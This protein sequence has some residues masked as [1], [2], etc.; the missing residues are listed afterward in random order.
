MKKIINIVLVTCLLCLNF[1][2][3]LFADENGFDGVYNDPYDG[4]QTVKTYKSMDLDLEKIDLKGEGNLNYKEFIENYDFTDVSDYYKKAATELAALGISYGI[5]NK[6]FGGEQKIKNIEA[7]AMLLRMFNAEEP[8]RKKVIDENKEASI[9]KLN[10]YF[11]DA[12]VEEAQNRGILSKEESLP[13]FHEAK[14]EDIADW[15][16]K[17]SN[18]SNPNPR[19]LIEKASDVGLIKSSNYTSVETLVDLGIMSISFGNEFGTKKPVKRRDFAKMLETTISRFENVLN[20]KKGH[21]MIIGFRDVKDEK[22]SYK[23]I[24]LRTEDNTIESLRYGKQNDG[25]SLGFPTLNSKLLYPEQLQ[26]NNELEYLIKD[27]KIILA[28]ILHSNEVKLGIVDK[29]AKDKDVEIIQGIVKSNKKEK[30]NTDRKKV[31]INRLRVELDDDRVV[32]FVDEKDLITGIN[33]ELLVKNGSGFIPAESISV[34]SAI[35]A[36]IKDDKVLFIQTGRK[37][38]EVVKGELRAID[39]VSEPKTITVF[40]ENSNLVTLPVSEDT[41][42]TVN[43]YKVGLNSLKVGS[44]V[45]VISVR[46]VAEFVKL[47][48]YQPPEGYIK[49]QGKIKFAVVNS[50]D[51]N[52]LKLNGD[53]DYCEITPLTLIKKGKENIKISNILVGDKVKLYYDDIYTDSPSKIVVEETGALIKKIL[54]AEISDYS[55]ATQEI[56]IKNPFT[57]ENS[58]WEIENESYTSSYKLSYDSEIFVNGFKIKKENLKPDYIGKTAYMVIR[59]GLNSKE[60][61]K[62]VFSDKYEKNI[63]DGIL[64]FDNT[65]NRL[66]L[67]GGKTIIFNDETIFIEKDR[68]VSKDSLRKGLNLQ[69]ITNGSDNFDTAKLVKMLGDDT[70]NFNK[71]FIAYI[72][73][74]N[75]FSVDIKNYAEMEKTKFSRVLTEKKNL[76]ISDDTDIFDASLGNYVSRE[77]FFNGDYYKK[78]YKKSDNK[79]LKFKR[80]YGLFITDGEDNLIAAKI[81]HKGLLENDIID[82]KLKNEFQVAEHLDE[83]INGLN[84]TKGKITEFQ[85]KWHRVKLENSFNHFS[86]HNEWKPNDKPTDVSLLNALIMKKNKIINYEDLKI[87]DKLFIVRDDEDGL[88]VF[89]E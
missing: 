45:S 23:D 57:Y 49:K 24:L 85:P 55:T 63:N 62:L 80:Y 59:D 5:G 2:V 52:S 13:Y 34:D 32:D 1:E 48:S 65:L 33:N 67:S 46:G 75:P 70:K 76:K 83:I 68:L 84:F 89:V 14:R 54:K 60:I 30:I 78:E 3:F 56:K 77:S 7:I 50:V 36:Y 35:T 66:T 88:L 43:Y 42:Y 87:N 71:V 19:R 15:F 79:G 81:R 27:G 69:I 72:D 6:K 86:Y 74:V 64:N 51:K 37:A 21:G 61:S 16:V 8:I 26:K 17:A 28:R 9:D 11:Y 18:L 25:R 53:I 12:Y 41:N 44:F 4:I 40:D 47:A 22:G 73:N 10:L 38:I 39:K 58:K 82:D 31:E 20:V 29:F